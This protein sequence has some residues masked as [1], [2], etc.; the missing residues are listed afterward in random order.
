MMLNSCAPALDLSQS[1]PA[2]PSDRA[3][4][5]AW[6]WCPR[7]RATSVFEEFWSVATTW[8]LSD[9]AASSSDV[10]RVAREARLAFDE[11]AA[12]AN[13]RALVQELEDEVDQLAVVLS[14]SEFCRRLKVSRLVRSRPP[15]R[16]R[17]RGCRCRGLPRPPAAWACGALQSL[18]RVCSVASPAP[19]RAQHAEP[20]SLISWVVAEK[21]IWI[22]ELFYPD[23]L[24][25]SP[26]PSFFRSNCPGAG[27]W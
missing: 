18:P 6:R 21:V 8:A 7:A 2:L 1:A 15:R 12:L 23:E 17:D 3:T 22:S 4:A 27:R 26:Y 9:A 24:F 19:S 5:R 16:R 13:L 25:C 20:S 11:A 10:G 14:L